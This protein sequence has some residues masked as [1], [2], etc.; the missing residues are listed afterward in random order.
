MVIDVARCTVAASLVERGER[1]AAVERFHDR[2]SGDVDRLVV[3]RVDAQLAEVHRPR[4]AVADVRPAP[5]LVLRSED[6]AAS[7][8]ERGGRLRRSGR[9]APPKPRTGRQLLHQ[10]RLR[11]ALRGRSRATPP[12]TA[13]GRR[14]GARPRRRRRS[15]GDGAA[16]LACSRLRGLESWRRSSTAVRP[17]RPRSGRRARSGSSARHRARFARRCPAAGRSSASSTISR[18]RSSST[19]RCPARRR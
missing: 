3:G 4:I 17:G 7:R 18:R 9:G 15:A 8:V 14:D 2:Q 11:R 1:T 6:A 19:T 12:A 10:C 16:R 13:G 5:A